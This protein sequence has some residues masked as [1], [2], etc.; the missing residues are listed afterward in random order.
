M[1]SMGIRDTRM[2][3]KAMTQRW[4]MKPEY[5]AA[6]I[7]R[8]VRIVADPESSPR[9][10]TA[11]SKALIAAEAQNQ[12]DDRNS[13]TNDNRSRFLAIAERLGASIVP[14]RIA[15]SGTVDD[16]GEAGE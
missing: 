6:I 7:S 4:D 10:V 14:V 5:K 1:C 2:M 15:D 8:L 16:F 12:T 11:A 3:A 13:E 9:E